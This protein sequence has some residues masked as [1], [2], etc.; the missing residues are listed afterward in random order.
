[1]T[2]ESHPKT[3]TASSF[4]NLTKGVMKPTGVRLDRAESGGQG[5]GVPPGIGQLY[6]RKGA[7]LDISYVR[8][9]VWGV[10]WRDRTMAMNLATVT[11]DRAPVRL[12]GYET[13]GE[14]RHSS[15][16]DQDPLD[17]IQLFCESDDT[18]RPGLLC[19]GFVKP[20]T[21]ACPC[22]WAKSNKER[23][24]SGASGLSH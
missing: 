18:K 23:S 13:C 6:V 10:S 9:S 7:P 11:T 4:A 5:V 17:P 16:V 19:V 1:M 20:T 21:T 3:Q 22:F 15:V 8:D 24:R 12:T 14:C 2:P